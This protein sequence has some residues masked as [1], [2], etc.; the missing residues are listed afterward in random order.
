[1]ADT[2]SPFDP[3]QLSEIE[4]IQLDIERDLNPDFSPPVVREH[5]PTAVEPLA[6]HAVKRISIDTDNE[7]VR[8]K[9]PPWH[10]SKRFRRTVAILTIIC[11]LGTGTLGVGAGFGMVFM[12]NR[13]GAGISDEFAGDN[14]GNAPHIDSRQLIFGQGTSAE[15]REGTLA[16]IVTLVDPSVVSL[17]VIRDGIEYLPGEEGFYIPSPG[18]FSQQNQG[19]QLPSGGSGIIFSEND[20]RVFIAT[21]SH[22]IGGA[23]AVFVSIEGHDAIPASAVGRNI[24]FDLA[25]ISVCKIEMQRVGINTVSIATFGNSDEMRA[26]DVVL[27]IGN[28]MGE[29]NSTTI[30]IISA[31]EKQIEHG[32]STL[33]VLQT[34]AA[35]NPGNSGGPLVNK[36]GEVI[37]INTALPSINHYAVEGIGF[38]IS[39]RIAMPILEHLLNAPPAPAIG[40]MGFTIRE[41]QAAEFNLPP[42][43]VWVDRVFSGSG[44]AQAGIRPQ[45]LITGFNG[46]TIFNMEQLQEE[47]QGLEIGDTVQVNVIREGRRQLVLQVTLGS[48]QNSDNF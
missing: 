1:M 41:S 37:G 22:V 12:Q 10:K 34:D 3:Y 17:S 32:N 47:I 7:P 9:T 2:G 13:L 43:G 23:Q 6:L 30:G 18:L 45:D 20:E 11:T 27:A 4:K 38:S 14:L 29:G 48:N 16:D 5:V 36:R 42:I 28:A 21:N 40:I 15:A 24:M 8:Q 46:R 44:A 25:V 33:T 35:I 19:P 26:G 31:A 39:S